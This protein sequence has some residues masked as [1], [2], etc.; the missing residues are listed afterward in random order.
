MLN[1]YF[2]LM[3]IAQVIAA[4]SQVLLKISAGKKY[5]TVIREY[6]NAFVIG[7]YVLLVVSMLIAIFCYKGLDY[8]AVVIME[9]I[10]YVLVMLLSRLVFKEGITA[11][12]VAG[13]IL[14]IGGIVVFNVL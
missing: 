5:P 1:I 11:R 3:I 14:I 7:G 10:S 12:K 6:L 4:F 8:M 2:L 13:M 9:P